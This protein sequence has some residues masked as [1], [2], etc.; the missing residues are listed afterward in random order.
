M[1]STPSAKC[2]P[3]GVNVTRQKCLIQHRC[4]LLTGYVS[5]P[6]SFR[7]PTLSTP[8]SSI[9]SL[10]PTIR[11]DTNY[12][13]EMRFL[14]KSYA[15][16]PLEEQGIAGGPSLASQ[17][18]S[19]GGIAGSDESPGWKLSIRKTTTWTNPWI[20]HLIVLSI[21]TSIYFYVQ[22]M[23]AQKYQHASDLVYSECFENL[24]RSISTGILD[25]GGIC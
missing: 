15:R 1:L 17:E 25:R 16:V 23:I 21:Y 12:R 24:Y 6:Y 8:S 2:T 5:R 3:I 9:W 10:P 4:P 18:K 22:I 13:E 20:L 19:V 14:A 11:G 7:V